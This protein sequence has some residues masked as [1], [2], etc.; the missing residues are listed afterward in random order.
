VCASESHMSLVSR[1]VVGDKKRHSVMQTLDELTEGLLV[2][3]ATSGLDI[4][5]QY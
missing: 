1:E 3:V 5:Q 2:V 4:G